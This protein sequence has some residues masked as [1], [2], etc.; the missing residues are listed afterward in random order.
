MIHWTRTASIAPGKLTAAQAFAAEATAYLKAHHGQ[1][2]T[3]SMPIG[4][5]PNRI[6]WAGQLPSLAAYE[7]Y[8]AALRADAGYAAVLAK[9]SDL[10]IAGSIHDEFWRSA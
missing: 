9:G 8:T 5:N 1:D 3:V 2:F 4:G 6:R 7:A 10:F